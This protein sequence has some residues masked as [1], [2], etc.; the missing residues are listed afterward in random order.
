MSKEIEEIEEIEEIVDKIKN[1]LDSDKL[2][3]DIEYFIQEKLKE[4][5]KYENL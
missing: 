4:V 2:P 3:L 1:K 5:L